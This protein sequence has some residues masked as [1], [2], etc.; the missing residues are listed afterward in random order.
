MTL[1]D[2][3]TQ[4]TGDTNT[5]QWLV[6]PLAPQPPQLLPKKSCLSPSRWTDFTGSSCRVVSRAIANVLYCS[7]KR[8]ATASKGLSIS[9]CRQGGKSL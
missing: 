4:D 8:L 1:R 3:G 9:I 5:H 7:R 2:K 6:L